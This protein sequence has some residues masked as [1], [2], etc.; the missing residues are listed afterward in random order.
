MAGVKPL[1][2]IVDKWARVAAGA[3]AEYTAGVEDP[4]RDW[5]AATKA[6]EDAYN[7]GIQQAVSAKRFGKGVAKAGTEKWKRMALLKGPHR[8]S[9]GIGHA[10]NDYATAFAPYHTALGAISYPAK[11]PRGDPGNIARVAVVAKTLHD[12]KLRIKGGG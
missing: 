4:R 9:E 8:W 6:A 11:G 1:D 12:L 5:A 2:K 3:Q 7:K 10:K